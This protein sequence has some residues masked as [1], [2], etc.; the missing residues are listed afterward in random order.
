[1]QWGGMCQEPR[2]TA[3][4]LNGWGQLVLKSIFLHGLID[5]CATDFVFFTLGNSL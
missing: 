3:A 5:W 1:M 2:G 4:T